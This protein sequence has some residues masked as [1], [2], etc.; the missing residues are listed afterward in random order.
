MNKKPYYITTAIPFVN[1]KPHVGFALEIIQT[2]A[3]ARYQRLFGR[4]GYRNSKYTV[5]V[6]FEF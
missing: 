6:R 3:L 2:D 1:A 4:D 5:G